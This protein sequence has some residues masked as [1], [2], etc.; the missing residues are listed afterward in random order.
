[1]TT[2]EWMV[3]LGGAMAIA[4]VNWYFFFAGRSAM[5]QAATEPELEEQ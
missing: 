4:W 1:M 5:P 2:A 3:V